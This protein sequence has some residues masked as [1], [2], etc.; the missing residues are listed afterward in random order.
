MTVIGYP[1]TD[2]GLSLAN[3]EG[4]QRLN[5]ALST[6]HFILLAVPA[7]NVAADMIQKNGGRL[8]WYTRKT[9]QIING[10]RQQH[11]YCK[12]RATVCGRYILRWWTSDHTN[13]VL[14]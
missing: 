13:S 14:L 9:Y 4:V 1:R 7:D 10:S 12:E 11:R 6:F 5:F 8:K 2:W 3:L